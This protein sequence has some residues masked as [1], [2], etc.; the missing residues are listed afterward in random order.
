[1]LMELDASGAAPWGEAESL[2]YAAADHGALGGAWLNAYSRKD[3]S[4]GHRLLLASQDHAMQLVQ[5]AKGG[6]GLPTLSRKLWK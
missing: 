5:A 1:M 4:L 3:G 6:S 2:P